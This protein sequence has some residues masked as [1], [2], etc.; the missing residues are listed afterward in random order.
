MTRIARLSKTDIKIQTVAAL[1][2]VIAA[3][4]LPQAMHLLGIAS[5]L[6]TALGETFLPMHLPIILTGLIAGPFAGAIAGAASPAISFLLTGMPSAVM[7][8]FIVIEL[9]SYGL[10]AGLLRDSK[11]PCAAKVLSVQ[12]LGRIV[13]AAAILIAVYG[14]SY[15]GLATKVIYASILTGLPGLILQWCLIPLIIFWVNNYSKNEK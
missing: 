10:F 6:G 14:F 7:L 8:P 3:V 11:M 9:F 4:A 15:E 1:L 13:R 5:G 2:A 12:V